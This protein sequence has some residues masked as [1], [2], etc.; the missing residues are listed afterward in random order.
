MAQSGEFLRAAEAAELLRCS[1]QKLKVD[2]MHRR[3]LPFIKNGRSVLYRRADIIAHLD[4][5]VVEPIAA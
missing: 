3:G 4:A 2:R 1:E 5:R